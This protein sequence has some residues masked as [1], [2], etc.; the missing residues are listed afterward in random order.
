MLLGLF[1]TVATKGTGHDW[2]GQCERDVSKGVSWTVKPLEIVESVLSDEEDEKERMEG[3]SKCYRR[4]KG[5]EK[6]EK[7]EGEGKGKGNGR[8]L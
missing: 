8:L 7:G 1:V 3:S 2:V 4:V 6:I 5:K